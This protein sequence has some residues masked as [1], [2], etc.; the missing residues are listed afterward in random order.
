MSFG[1]SSVSNSSTTDHA[2]F[3]QRD[4]GGVASESARRNGSPQRAA[5]WAG[6]PLTAIREL[7]AQGRQPVQAGQ[8]QASFRDAGP[9]TVG[10][11]SM[12]MAEKKKVTAEDIKKLYADNDAK[13]TRGVGPVNITDEQAQEYAD[14]MN[15]AADTGSTDTSAFKGLGKVGHVVRRIADGLAGASQRGVKPA[16]QF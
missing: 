12:A 5:L 16:F 9:Q 7:V 2:R 11:T 10:P 3:V 1:T 4:E 15:E 13:G 8:R 14:A 6:H